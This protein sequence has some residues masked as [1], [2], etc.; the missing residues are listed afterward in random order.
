MKQKGKTKE[1]A[2]LRTLINQDAQNFATRRLLKDLDQIKKE[3]IPTVGVTACPL[4][5]DL[6]LW[7]ANIRGP[8]GTPYKG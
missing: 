5:H 1:T 8:E 3:T 4:E 6:F 7:H 2:V